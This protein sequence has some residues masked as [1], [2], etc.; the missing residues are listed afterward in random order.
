MISVGHH[1]NLQ[2]SQMQ[3]VM[4]KMISLPIWE[5]VDLRQLRMSQLQ[6]DLILASHHLANNSSSQSKQLEQVRAVQTPSL[7]HHKTRC[8]QQPTKRIQCHPSHLNNN[9]NS[10]KRS[11]DSSPTYNSC[12]AISQISSSS[13]TCSW[14]EAWAINSALIQDKWVAA[15][16][17]AWAVA[18]PISLAL[19]S[20]NKT[21]ICLVCRIIS[22]VRIS[23]S[24]NLDR[25]S[26]AQFNNNLEVSVASTPLDNSKIIWAAIT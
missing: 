14:V 3:A 5:A 20:R 16:E 6:L 18:W 24:N 4:I 2:R 25:I 13:K 21:T 23:S 9:N 10:S 17:A 26:L 11:K 8:S 15:W 12:K 22:L 7:H 19:G 1:P